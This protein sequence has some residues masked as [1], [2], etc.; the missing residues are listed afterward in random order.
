MGDLTKEQFGDLIEAL[1]DAFPDPLEMQ[2]M[3]K[4]RLGR[5]MFAIANTRVY[6]SDIFKV[7]EKAEAQGWT[8][9][10]I[11][12]ARAA[13]PGNAKL[14]A[15]AAQFA[16]ASAT[17][18][19]ARSLELV[20]KPHNKM[21]NVNK[22]L[23]QLG[24]LETQVCRV[25][26]GGKFYG[27]GFLV[28]PGVV[29]TNY[30]VIAPVLKKLVQPENVILRFDYQ[31]PANAADDTDVE[32]NSE[33]TIGTEYHLASPDWLL[34]SREFSKA[35]TSPAS[36]N[37]QPHPTELDY[38]LLAVDGSPG[39][40]YVGRQAGAYDNPRGWIKFTQA[41]L[42]FNADDPMLILQHPRGTYLKLAI[43][44][45]P[46]LAY[47]TNH[48]RLRYTTNTEPG[49]SGSPC[50]TADWELIALHHAGDPEY[51]DLHKPEYNQGIPIWLVYADLLEQ[52]LESYF[53]S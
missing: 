35:D 14:L 50:F 32:G 37:L 24:V 21:W 9:D 31:Q 25:E 45:S 4:V 10:L 47:D 51:S 43:E 52:G 41:E 8:M 46:S 5:S 29:L 27:T 40:E 36:A 53:D 38:A 49:S 18:D 44:T 11:L 19:Q 34:A 39:K 13:N 15:F 17:R 22:F 26:V 28:G 2:E 23:A 7:I 12:G 48:T 1:L 33:E 16:L 6:R 3:M 30:H 42:P 20:V